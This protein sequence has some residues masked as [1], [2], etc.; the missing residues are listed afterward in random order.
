MEREIVAV[1]VETETRAVVIAKIRATTPVPSGVTLTE[2]ESSQRRD[3]FPY[4]YVLEK[5]KDGWK[6]EQI[7]TKDIISSDWEPMFKENPRQYVASYVYGI[8]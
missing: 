1:Q 6:I 4:K 8:Q 2:R 7:Y 3:G 5:A